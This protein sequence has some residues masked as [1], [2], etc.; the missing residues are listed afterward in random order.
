MGSLT[1]RLVVSLID[2]VSGPAKPAAAALKNITAAEKAAAAAAKNLKFFDIDR[3]FSKFNLS[4]KEIRAVTRDLEALRSAV[5][6][7]KAS[8]QLGALRMWKDA[9]V[10]DLR[11]IRHETR[12]VDQA[13]ERMFRGWRGGARMAAGALGVG[14]AA[15]ATQRV[16]RAAVTATA[17]N[18]R[19]GA[20]DYL[21]GLT[22]EESARLKAS[23]IGLAGQYPSVSME[24]MHQ[25]LRETATSMRSIDNA[26]VIGDVLAKG[27]AVLQS[28]KGK[29]EALK[30]S[31][32]F[33]SALDTLGKNIN[34]GEVRELM[35]G[36]LKALGVEG[37]DLKMADL[38]QITQKSKAAGPALSN[39]FLM[40]TAPGL[41]ADMGA[42]SLGTSLG[43]EIAQVIAD[44]A[45]KKAKAAQAEF[46]LRDT[47]GW[48]RRT[49]IMTDPDKFAW[50]DLIPALKKKGIDPDNAPAVTEAMNKL[51]SNQKVADL[52]TKLITQRQQYEG[53]S[54]QYEK[55]PGLAA[56]TALRGKDPFV[57]LEG[58]TSTLK[59]FASVVSEGPMQSAVSGL[60]SLTDSIARLTKSLA[61]NPELASKAGL[62]T[63]AAATAGGVGT[64]LAARKAYQW[65]TGAA[66][67][68]AAGGS[69]MV[70][71]AAKFAGKRL[72][73]PLGVVWGLYELADMVGG[74]Y[75]RGG[76]DTGAR[77]AS[78]G[79]AKGAYGNL[80]SGLGAGLPANGDDIW[81]G[82]TKPVDFLD[83]SKQAAG[84]GQKTGE[85]YKTS[86]ET[87]LQQVDATIEAAVQ[88]WIGKLS[89]S[90]R[91]TITPN[92]SNPPA[93]KQG[94]LGSN[95]SKQA[96]HADYGFGTTG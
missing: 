70:G 56:A 12:A 25:S 81:S 79:K 17:G 54:E 85:A 16:G 67:G 46:G 14:S 96:M 90:A 31:A 32:K 23:A 38:K 4:G 7:M 88:R 83:G 34:P 43:S 6:G 87:A 50:E 30:E 91:P 39:R 64:L 40:M 45:T 86:L 24:T 15:Y 10:R 60:N 19:E 76:G 89:F 69:G 63:G 26:L 58:L 13:R 84:A 37:V 28:L 29:D 66:G 77:A 95:A 33:F 92:I 51:F 5:A 71:S 65:F 74:D 75:G 82:G 49:K 62:A 73:G 42:Q 35:D 11:A 53:K 2:K 55:A 59:N 78:S 20:R 18:I 21:A 72:L 9:T 61:D 41:Q 44:R 93:Q 52:F 36:Y 94:S 47:S 80:M 57:A 68:A 27:L 48:R 8:D 1:S 3:A 22:P